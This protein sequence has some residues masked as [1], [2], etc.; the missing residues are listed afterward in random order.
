MSNIDPQ[1]HLNETLWAVYGPECF[2]SIVCCRVKICNWD[3]KATIWGYS[4]YEGVPG[5][6]TLGKNLEDWGAENDAL[7]FNDH[8]AA[9][10]HLKK[11][12]TPIT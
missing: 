10:S 8:S 4:I 6:R 9:I 2:P 12:T 7:F 1:E 5:F 3:R 11:L